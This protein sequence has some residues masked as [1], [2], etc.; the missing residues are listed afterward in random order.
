[1]IEEAI[2]G[3]TGDRYVGSFRGHTIELVRLW[4]RG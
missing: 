2:M 1:M 3:L 4:G